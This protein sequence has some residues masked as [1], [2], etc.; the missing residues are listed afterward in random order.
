MELSPQ[1][2]VQKTDTQVSTPLKDETILLQLESGQYFSLNELGS[3]IWAE[4]STPQTVA[5]LCAKVLSEYEVDELTCVSEVTALLQ[6]LEQ[7][8]MIELG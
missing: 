3:F 2:R 6:H 7:E 1:T 8:K 4:L 5:D